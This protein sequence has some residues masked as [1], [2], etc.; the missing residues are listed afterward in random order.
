MT[1]KTKMLSLVLLT[2]T[3]A[4]GAAR[5]ETSPADATRAEIVSALGFLPA[6]LKAMP[7]SALPGA[8][9][10]MKQFENADTALPG[11]VKDLI[12]LAVSA[13]VPSRTGVYAYTRCA[14]AQGASEAEVKEAVAVAALSRHWSTYFNGAQLDEARFR[15][16]S[17]Q[18]LEY[19]GKL[20]AGKV[21]PPR[22]IDVVDARTAMEDMQQLFG[23]VPDFIKKFPPEALA[24]AWTELKS[25]EMAET[26]IPGKYKSL[27]G[28]AVAA[29]IPCRYCVAMD[30]A[31]AKA[32]GATD[33][34]I[35][36]AIAMASMTRHLT[37][38]VDGLQVDE[39]A[40]RRDIDRL[41]AAAPKGRMARASR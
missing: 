3:L 32:D 36:E 4:A 24:G 20:A 11:K 2:A 22:P 34:E 40:V 7:D 10:E 28:V 37:T 16:E 18:M 19:V 12:A 13:Q 8:W 38:L 35:S 15:A 29:Q 41:T 23:F 6:H 21:P 25:V 31:F 5:A 30:T 27:I 39:K 1:H 26:A 17:A 9:A 14:R 33:R